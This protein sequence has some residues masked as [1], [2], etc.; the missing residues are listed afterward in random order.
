MSCSIQRSR[1]EIMSFMNMISHNKP[2][3]RVQHED[4]APNYSSQPYLEIP[5]SLPEGAEIVV[6]KRFSK[7]FERK[8]EKSVH[9]FAGMAKALSTNKIYDLSKERELLMVDDGATRTPGLF[10]R[11]IERIARRPVVSR[12]LFLWK[13]I[14]NRGS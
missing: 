3:D 10:E 1:E 2:R 9:H 6:R 11:Q 13:D 8:K 4:V 7:V 14:S 5:C 12:I